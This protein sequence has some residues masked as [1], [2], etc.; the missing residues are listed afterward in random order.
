MKPL[1]KKPWF[2][3]KQLGWGWRPITWE[4]WLTTLVLLGVIYFA[5]H[6]SSKSVP[7][8]LGLSFLFCIVAYLTG[9]KPG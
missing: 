9:G 7:V 8:I 4:G 1:T 3:P 2:G 6:H 5:V